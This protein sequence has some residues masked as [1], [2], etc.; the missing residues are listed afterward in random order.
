M[1]DDLEIRHIAHSRE[2]FALG[3]VKVAEWIRDKKGVLSMDD[4]LKF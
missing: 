3:A 1:I 2:G 4:Y